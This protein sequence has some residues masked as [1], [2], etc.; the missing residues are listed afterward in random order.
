MGSKSSQM[1]EC[2]SDCICWVVGNDD[3]FSHLH[4]DNITHD[5]INYHLLS[6]SSTP[7]NSRPVNLRTLKEL[8]VTLDLVICLT[9]LP[10]NMFQF[11]QGIALTQ[12]QN[13]TQNATNP[14]EVREL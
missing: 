13:C 2:A 10:K 7:K 14:L 5:V 6:L 9:L 3:L 11:R 1:H 8:L 12:P 4:S